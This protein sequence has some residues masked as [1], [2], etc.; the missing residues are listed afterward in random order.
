MASDI[1]RLRLRLPNGA[2]FEA[3][4]PAEFVKEQLGDFLERQNAFRAREEAE[5][6]NRAREGATPSAPQADTIRIKWSSIIETQGQDIFLRAKLGNDKNEGD[7]CLILIAASHQ[8]LQNSR[9]AALKLAKW[10]R[11][12]GYPTPRIDRI[13]QKSADRGETLASGSRRS[14]RYELTPHGKTKA[15]LLAETLT[16]TI[17]GSPQD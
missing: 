7:A 9:P 17:L 6:P 12:S 2:E 10:L 16:K 11:K 15:L 8:M 14:R 1:S 5:K 3:K 13:L 4:G